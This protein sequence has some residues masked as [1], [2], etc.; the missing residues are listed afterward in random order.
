MLYN[1]KSNSYKCLVR[2]KLIN[3]VGN[4]C[5]YIQEQNINDISK[6]DQIMDE[7]TPAEKERV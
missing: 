6:Y 4:I 3:K 2:I 1:T 7:R 5:V